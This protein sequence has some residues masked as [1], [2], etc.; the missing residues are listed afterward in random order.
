MIEVINPATERIIAHLQPADE[1]QVDAAVEAAERALSGPWSK[2]S[3]RERGKILFRIAEEIRK[4]KEAL[5]QL[6]TGN[7][8]K[9]IRD[10]RDEVDLAANCF[11]YYGGAVTKFYGE[12]NPVAAKGLS[13]TL[14]EPIGVCALI[15]PWNYPLVIACWKLAPAL[16]CGNTIVLKPASWTPLT[17]I[18]LGKICLKA[19]V[20]EG[21]VHVLVGPGR[22]VGHR[23]VSHP[24][25]AKISLT[26]ETETGKEILRIAAG[27][28][29][30]V[31][32]ELGGK[33]PNIVF[34]DVDVETVVNGSVFSVFSNC[35]QDCCARSRF[36]IH[37][38]IYDRFLDA[39]VKRSKAI[40]VGDPLDEKTEV[41]PMISAA[42]RQT[43]LNY[44]AAGQKEKAKL[45]CGGTIPAAG[46]GKTKGYYILPAVF[47][48]A[49][50][51]MTIVQEEIF[52]PV[53][54]VLP[55]SNEE[56][57]VTLANDTMYGLSG[58]LWT[59]DLGRAIR[60]AKAVKTGVLSVNSSSS[61]FLESPFGGYKQ[62][63]LGREL[64][65][66]ALDGYSETKAVFFSEI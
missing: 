21:V 13:V 18:E 43:V 40:K 17:A 4:N 61:V 9:P 31:S 66:K 15:V 7:T 24:K 59:R 28:L 29:K 47:A 1:K 11:E 3:P 26:G 63:G 22:T 12:V 2:L 25:V 39:L 37:K 52:G 14:K 50:P 49:K 23:L 45:C 54:A 65:M 33:S 48:D 8:G 46:N 34:D 32:L 51:K 38:K 56:E 6:E 16:A 10:S 19:G 41:G 44:V 42:Q 35:G 58:S 57:A 27:T 62:S 55:F 64:G 53:V 30:R 20:P 5:A 60:V 36:I